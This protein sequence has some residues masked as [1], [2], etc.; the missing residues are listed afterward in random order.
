MV[1]G[2]RGATVRGFQRCSTRPS[3]ADGAVGRAVVEALGAWAN[4][5]SMSWHPRL[6]S[7]G[8]RVA[9]SKDTTTGEL[10]A[11][12][13]GRAPA[14]AAAR[15]VLAALNRS[16]VAPPGRS[17]GSRKPGEARPVLGPQSAA[18]LPV[19]TNW[20]DGM[21]ATLRSCRSTSLRSE[22]RTGSLVQRSPGFIV[23]FG[24]GCL[25]LSPCVCLVPIL[26]IDDVRRRVADSGGANRGPGAVVD[27]AVRGRFQRRF[28]PFEAPPTPCP[29]LCAT[30]AVSKTSRCLIVVMDW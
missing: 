6:P 11:G 27:P 8:G 14:D 12:R 7:T 5:P 29:V 24:A 28:R 4:A 25:F 17:S 19:K 20:A 26:P 3:P 16:G 13:H 30:Q 23:A 18:S 10:R 22:R 9:R 2:H 21:E 15:A 1:G